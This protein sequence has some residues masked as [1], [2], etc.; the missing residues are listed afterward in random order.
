MLLR[1]LS[2]ATAETTVGGVIN[3][4]TISD[5]FKISSSLSHLTQTH[6]QI[7]THGFQ[8]DI[9]LL[10]KL[11]Q[12]LSELGAIHY[13]RDHSV[14]DALR[15]MGWLQG[16]VWSNAH[17]RE[18]VTAMKQQR[19]GAFTPLAPLQRFAELG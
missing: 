5:L 14:D 18:A 4:N 9:R 13:A 3:K 12:R 11:T 15:Q 19:P 17:V 7:T 10:T 2:A 8:N 6:A 16:T 1:S